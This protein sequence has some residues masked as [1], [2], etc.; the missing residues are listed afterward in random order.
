MLRPRSTKRVPAE[1]LLVMPGK[2]E[3]TVSL[4]GFELR[5]GV[6]P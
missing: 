6:R 5:Q 4:E 1:C 2:S 3:Y